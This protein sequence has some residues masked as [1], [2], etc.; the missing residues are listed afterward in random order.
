MTP[1][2]GPS[3]SSS[4]ARTPATTCGCASRTAEQPVFA[5][6]SS[7]EREGVRVHTSELQHGIIFDPVHHGLAPVEAPVFFLLVPWLIFAV[8]YLTW[9]RRPYILT[10]RLAALAVE[11]LPRTTWPRLV[12]SERE[13]RVLLRVAAGF[14]RLRF[15]STPRLVPACAATYSQPRFRNHMSMPP[16]RAM[17]TA[18]KIG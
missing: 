14:G 4:P 12:L 18:Q 8:R 3:L 9:Q 11:P 1:C 17:H 15:A 7:F 5:Y 6:E 13:R 16:A 2:T 10:L